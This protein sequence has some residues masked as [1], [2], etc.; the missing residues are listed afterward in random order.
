MAQQFQNQPQ[1][2]TRKVLIIFL[3]S[4]PQP[5]M[6]YSANPQKDYE[7]LKNMMKMP[8]IM[9]NKEAVGPIKNYCMLS[10]N[11]LGVMLQDEQ[12]T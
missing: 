10:N 9:I 12:Y 8:N 11:I 3:K 1:V 7:E 5:I 2:K 6:I 4:A